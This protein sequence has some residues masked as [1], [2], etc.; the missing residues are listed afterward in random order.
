LPCGIIN[1]PDVNFIVVV[2]PNN[3]PGSSP[4]PDANYIREILKLTT[5]DNVRLLGYVATGYA[6][7]DFSLVRKD[8]ETYAEWPSESSN[9]ALA[10]RGIFFDETPQEY[11]TNAWAYLQDLTNMVKQSKSLGPDNFVSFSALV[12][13][14]PIVFTVF[15]GTFLHRLALLFFLL[16]LVV[17]K[18]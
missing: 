13:L 1:H 3:G 6:N 9:P 10:V 5:H 17:S 14:A 2:N 15:Y 12:F 18:A 8:I 4:L 16:P 7:R 11:N